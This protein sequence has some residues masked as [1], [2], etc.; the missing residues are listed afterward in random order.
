MNGTRR[1]YELHFGRS[2]ISGEEVKMF[3][4]MRVLGDW[5]RHRSA[6]ALCVL[7]AFG[8]GC[9]AEVTPDHSSVDQ[10]NKAYSLAVP[11]VREAVGAYILFLACDH[12]ESCHDQHIKNSPLAPFSLHTLQKHTPAIVQQFFVG[13]SS[14]ATTWIPALD[15]MRADLDVPTEIPE[16]ISDWLEDLIGSGKVDPF[17][18]KL[19][20]KLANLKGAEKRELCGVVAL[21]HGFILEEVDKMAGCDADKTLWQQ[22]A[23]FV[24]SLLGA[25]LF[26]DGPFTRYESVPIAT[27]MIDRISE[28]GRER[29]ISCDTI[30]K[31]EN[32]LSKLWLD[33]CVK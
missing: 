20:E 4:M 5:K 17:L 6:L 18:K 11:V 14:Q 9:A 3:S 30:Q 16:D 28:A 10:Q 7:S 12:D 25:L 2:C 33:K 19:R 26:G 22:G 23:E 24:A 15:K 13:L 1:A 21:L 29:S 8:L 32:G 31:L 27:S